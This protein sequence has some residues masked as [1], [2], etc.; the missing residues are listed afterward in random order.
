MMVFYTLVGSNPTPEG[1]VDPSLA[2]KPGEF[3]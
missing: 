1:M 2:P 3:W